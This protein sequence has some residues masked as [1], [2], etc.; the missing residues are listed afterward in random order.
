[1]CNLHNAICNR[2]GARPPQV[3]RDFAREAWLL[4]EP[5]V[6]AVRASYYEHLAHWDHAWIKKWPLAKQLAIIKSQDSDLVSGDRCK[7][8]VKREVMHKPLSKAR[9]IQFYV[10]HAS[11]AYCGPEYTALQKALCATAYRMPLGLA[12]VTFASGMSGV[13]IGRW[14]EEVL[15]DYSR[16]VFYERDGKTWDASMQAPHGDFRIA[17]Y[18]AIDSKLA[19]YAQLGRS[20]KTK[21]TMDG[22]VFA[23]TL[24]DTVK[25]GHN[26]TTSGNSL[27]NML[28]SALAAN[29]LGVVCDIIVAGDDM[30]MVCGGVDA[31]AFASLEAQCGIQPEYRLFESIW[32]VSFISGQF[33]P[34][35]GGGLFFTPLAGRL[36]SRLWWTVKPP[37]QRR[38]ADYKHS[39][40]AGLIPACGE[41]PL[42]RDFLLAHDTCGRVIDVDKDFTV[43]STKAYGD[44]DMI[45]L[46]WNHRYGPVPP[47]LEFGGTGI[48]VH[49]YLETVVAR[50]C[51]SLADRVRLA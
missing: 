35:L 15:L 20:A 3:T 38:L 30:L 13:G 45:E 11:Q 17:L 46:V 9:A 44:P 10:N 29:E 33:W 12:R 6:A 42:M 2:H 47:G 41:I 49:P 39:V 37:S 16:P 23:Y 26:D 36:L 27:I 4:F 50:D 51:G 5:H 31:D 8:M 1:M 28:V 22:N 7:A 25:S 48:L 43:T 19:A 18:S 34:A 32:D 21:V 40:V 14:M 24:S